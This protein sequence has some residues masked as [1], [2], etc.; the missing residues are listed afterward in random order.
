MDSA[1]VAVEEGQI[2]ELSI[3]LPKSLDT[4]IYLRLST[5]AKAILLS[6]TT[7]SQDELAAPKPMGSFVYALPDVC[8]HCDPSVRCKHVL[9]SHSASTPSSRSP[10]PSSPMSRQWSSPLAWPSSSRGEPICQRTSPTR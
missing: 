1:A 8:G 6:L 5:Q 3:P 2:A 9:I 10:P 7:A 4:R